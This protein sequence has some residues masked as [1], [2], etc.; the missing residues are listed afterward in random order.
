MYNA[1]TLYKQYGVKLLTE[2]VVGVPGETFETALDTLRVNMKLKPDI[3]NASIF[4]P[5]PKLEMTEYAIEHGYFSGN[6]DSLNSN[7]YHG[8]VLKFKSERDRNRILNLRCFFS[9]LSHHPR[10]LPLVIPLLD[11]KHNTVFRW[12]GDIVDGYYLK[13]C[14]AYRLSIT[15]FL[16]TLRHFLTNYRQGSTAGRTAEARQPLV[17]TAPGLRRD[18]TQSPVETKNSTR[19]P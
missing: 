16:T 14:I 9:F 7:Y 11:I 19:I 4:A 13:R 15:D 12:F 3:A 5:Y 10:A 18:K 2:N 17:A 1:A 8:S 6:F